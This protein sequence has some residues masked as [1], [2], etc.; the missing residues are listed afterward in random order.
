MKVKFA[1]QV[2]SNSV[3]NALEFCKDALKLKYFQSCGATVRFIRTINNAF[4]IINSRLQGSTGFKQPLNPENI[5]GMESFI[6]E[7]IDYLSKL[8]TICDGWD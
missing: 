6:S 4:G 5:G 2:L 1:T 8:E 3:A 7:T